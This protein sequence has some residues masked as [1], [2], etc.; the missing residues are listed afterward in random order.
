LQQSLAQTARFLPQALR[1]ED[2]DLTWLRVIDTTRR[3][4]EGQAFD[5]S[6][7]ELQELLSAL[8]ARCNL[9]EKR[10]VNQRRVFEI[11]RIKDSAER[12]QPYIQ[13]ATPQ[14]WREIPIAFQ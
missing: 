3:L 2:P 4:G 14:I 1:M 8:I 9:L 12:L 6:R 10:W 7:K 13:N 11:M 5:Q